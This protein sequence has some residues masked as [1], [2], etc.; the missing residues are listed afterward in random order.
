MTAP[1]GFRRNKRVVYVAIGVNLGIAATKF[2]AAFSG[3][4]AMVSEGIH[5]LVDTGNQML[6]LLGIYNSQKPA[7]ATH[8]FGYGKELFFWSLIVAIVLFGIGGGMAIYEGVTHLIQPHLLED[9]TWAYIVL[10]AAAVFE[11]FSWYMAYREIL[12][13]RKGEGGLWQVIRHSKDPSVFTVLFEDSAALLGLLAAF[14]GIYFGH[15]LHDPYLDGAA[16]IVIGVTLCV[17]AL[18]LIRES[19]GLL[20]GEAADPE[21]IA[22]IVRI[23]SNDP[24][25]AAVNRVLTMYIGPSEV[26]LNLDVQFH[27]FLS[28]AQLSAT[29]RRLEQ[30]IRAQHPHIKRIFIEAVAVAASLKAAK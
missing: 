7:D 12:A 30:A 2:I 14:L 5:S 25:V 3:S 9:P 6:L 23:V 24:A 22:S 16:S 27:S 18:F 21:E 29:V 10:G 20:I 28:A 1:Q 19:R 17:V 13:T 26:L 11:A 4:S 8:P 15:L